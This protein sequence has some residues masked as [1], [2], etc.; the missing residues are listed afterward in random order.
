MN[1]QQSSPAKHD[2]EYDINKDTAAKG[3]EAVLALL[4]RNDVQ[5]YSMVI[6]SLLALAF[7]SIFAIKPTLTSFFDLQRQIADAKMLDQEL[8]TKIR[9]LLRVQEEYYRIREDLVMI[10]QALPA[11]PA[12]SSLLKKIEQVTAD[13]QTTVSTFTTEDF[14]LLEEGGTHMTKDDEIGNV[15]FSLET[16]A[17]YPNS[18]ALIRR[19]LN[20]RRMIFINRLELISNERSTTPVVQM[21]ISAQTFHLNK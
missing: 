13:E 1:K 6:F 19:L 21:E 8:T 17:P 11:D 10:D 12:F 18:E 3:H 15:S 5:A 2:T 4:S 7:F 9:M 16:D 20:L 14:S